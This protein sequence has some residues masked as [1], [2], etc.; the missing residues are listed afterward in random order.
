MLFSFQNNDSRRFGVHFG[1][2]VS[3]RGFGEDRGSLLFFLDRTFRDLSYD[4]FLCLLD[5]RLLF[6]L[7]LLPKKRS[8]LTLR[9]T[10]LMAVSLQRTRVVRM[11]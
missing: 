8:L 10:L 1:G 5:H 9:L 3:K 11:V 7:F 6:I 2:L 4:L